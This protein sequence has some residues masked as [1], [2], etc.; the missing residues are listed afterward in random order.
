VADL[1]LDDDQR[2]SAA[3]LREPSRRAFSVLFVVRAWSPD[4]A[5]AL[6]PPGVAMAAGYRCNLGL[7][8]GST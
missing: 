7:D 4:R 1:A 5:G 3:L 6:A 2:R 8:G